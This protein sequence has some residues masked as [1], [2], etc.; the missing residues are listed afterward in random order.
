MENPLP[1]DLVRAAKRRADIKLRMLPENLEKAALPGVSAVK[2]SDR[3]GS[4][5]TGTFPPIRIIVSC[6]SP[7]LSRENPLSEKSDSLNAN[8]VLS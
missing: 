7:D 1:E 4:S 5:P 3:T 2:G 8:T 6:P